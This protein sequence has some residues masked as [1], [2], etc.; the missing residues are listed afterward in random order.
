MQGKAMDVSAANPSSSISTA[1]PSSQDVL[2]P[3]AALDNDM[4]VLAKSVLQTLNTPENRGTTLALIKRAV[5][6]AKKLHSAKFEFSNDGPAA[7]K[8]KSIS[9]K[10]KQICNALKAQSPRGNSGP[11]TAPR[12]LQ[13]LDKSDDK[14]TIT[15]VIMEFRDLRQSIIENQAKNGVTTEIR[16]P[17][18]FD[19]SDSNIITNSPD[20]TLPI[21]VVLDLII[22][23]FYR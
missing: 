7:L 22:G 17:E 13:S 3:L 8:Y 9:K 4:D 1:A 12:M 10:S 19:V 16:Q 20:Y 5:E 6:N 23:K 2:G 15:E 18:E 14:Q 21:V 11:Q